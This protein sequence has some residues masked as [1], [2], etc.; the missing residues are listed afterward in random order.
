ML[1]RKCST[2]G[3]ISF[4]KPSRAS[5]AS[6]FAPWLDNFRLHDFPLRAGP[7]L[8]ALEGGSRSSPYRTPIF[9]LNGFREF[10]AI[11]L[12]RLFAKNFL[13]ALTDARS[14]TLSV[15]GVYPS[16]AISSI[17]LP[18]ESKSFLN[19]LQYVAAVLAVCC[20]S[21]CFS[22]SFITSGKRILSSAASSFVSTFEQAFARPSSGSCAPPVLFLQKAP[23]CRIEA[24]YVWPIPRTLSA[25]SSEAIAENDF[26]RS[27]KSLR[28]HLLYVTAVSGECTTQRCCSNFRATAS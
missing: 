18:S 1:L 13:N 8:P 2:S 22:K 21:K 26:L 7:S 14:T 28:K 27:Q 12:P 4:W 19:E 11:A 16:E 20:F 6:V 23:K 15:C 5:S 10:L 17:V 3:C 24:A 9:L 25:K